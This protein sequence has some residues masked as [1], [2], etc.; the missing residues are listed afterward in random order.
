VLVDGPSETGVVPRHSAALAHLSLTPIV[1]SKLPR[2]TG[3]G[4]VKSAWAKAEVDNK[5][6]ETTW[7]KKRAQ[8]QKR[9]QLNDFE[10]F[11]VMKLRKQVGCPFWIRSAPRMRPYWITGACG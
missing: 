8:Y 6:A 3:V 11:K 2:G 9:K 7:A 4:T 5:W 1:L 10:R